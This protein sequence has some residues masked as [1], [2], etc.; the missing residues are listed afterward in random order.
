MVNRATQQISARL[1]R[2]SL[3]LWCLCVISSLAAAQF[4]GPFKILNIPNKIAKSD[5]YP[6]GG[7]RVLGRKP[8][9]FADFSNFTIANAEWPIT[10]QELKVVGSVVTSSDLTSDIPSEHKPDTVY[11]FTEIDLSPTNLSF[12]TEAKAGVSYEFKGRYLKRGTLARFINKKIAVLD[13]ELTKH[14]DGVK[15]AGNRFRF[16]FVVWKVSYY[17]PQPEKKD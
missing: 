15:Q 11:Q 17:S 6:F 5:F 14:V 8:P 10:G 2:L 1:F 4:K 3:F 13:G 16:S 12:K 9:G 7:Y